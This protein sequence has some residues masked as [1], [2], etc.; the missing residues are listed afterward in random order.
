MM[1]ET[2]LHSAGARQI[3]RTRGEELGFVQNFSKVLD[4]EKIERSVSL[5][6]DA[7]YH[8]ERNGSAKMIFLDL[9]LN[10]SK[11]FRS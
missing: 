8:L 1:R 5:M 7:E 6:N 2:L 11:V 10:M 4:V 9:S 3:N